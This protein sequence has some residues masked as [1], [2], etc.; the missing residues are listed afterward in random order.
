MAHVFPNYKTKKAFKEAVKS[1]E[2]MVVKGGMYLTD[3]VREGTDFVEGPHEYH[4]WY[5]QVTIK[6][7]KVVK[8]S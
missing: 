2:A 8:V 6:D 5:A 3:T 4:K 1:G 7:G